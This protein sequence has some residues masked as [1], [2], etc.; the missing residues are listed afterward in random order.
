MKRVFAALGLAALMAGCVP[1]LNP[2]Y[3]EKDLTFDPA[4]VGVWAESDSTATWNFSKPGEDKYTL[5]HTDGEGHK[6]E[7]DVRLVKLKERQFIDL[8]LSKVGDPEIKLNDWAA[9]SLV[10]AHVILQVYGIGKTLKIA[11]MN[12]DW[13]KDYLEKHPEAIDHRKLPEDRFVLTAS[14]RDLQ[15][16]ILQHAGEGGVFGD[17]VELKRKDGPQ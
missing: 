5:L 11:A 15:K 2:I 13:L 9:I 8:Y 17:P 4:L 3:T 16:F 1:S 6:A 7:F 12:P 10:P 14:T